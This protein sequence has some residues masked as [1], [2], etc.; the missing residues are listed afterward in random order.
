MIICTRCQTENEDGAKFCKKCGNDLTINVDAPAQDELRNLANE[1]NEK[2]NVEGKKAF[3]LNKVISE[4]PKKFLHTICI[5]FKRLGK[6][7][8]II[9]TSSILVIVMLILLT[10]NYIIPLAP[11]Y[12]K[13]NSALKTEDY[14]TAISEFESAKSFLNAKSKLSSTHYLYAESLFAKEKYSDAAK[15]YS[16]SNNYDDASDKLY[17]CGVKLFDNKDYKNALTVFETI[18]TDEVK[19]LKDYAN[20][21]C[22]FNDKNYED[23]K[24][25][26]ESTGDY[27][28]SK[29]MINA[30]DL[31][32]A[33]NHC[34]NGNFDVAKQIYSSLPTDFAYD[35]ISAQGR[36]NLL[37]NSSALINA[38]GTWKASDNYIE[39]KNVNKRTGRWESWYLGHDNVLSGQELKFSFTMNSDNTFD[40]EG[41]VSFYKFDDY[42]SLSAY[43]KAQITS[44]SFAFR[45]V[46]TIP[47]NYQ[48]DNNTTLIYSG[49]VFSVKYSERDNYSTYFYNV[50]SSS[51]TY[52]FDEFS[53]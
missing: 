18:N 13:G 8:V 41:D 1:L 39:T 48:I 31:M 28:D 5:P 42:S 29:T 36:L 4:M 52:V 9:G 45:N 53:L 10:T 35:N 38:M 34:L 30:C 14:V 47:A 19:Q 44:R 43:C 24:K 15:H 33:E 40:I 11:H 20:G 46:T 49:G 21:M 27:K 25:I 3:N 51:V 37:N 22:T 23:A 50:Y 6:K 16:S 7:K 17:Q 2:A 12:F 32:I 26:F